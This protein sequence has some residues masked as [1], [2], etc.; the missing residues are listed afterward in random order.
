MKN[1]L[2]TAAISALMICSAQ[3]Q[4]SDNPYEGTY[5]GAMVGYNSYSLGDLTDV[6]GSVSEKVG[7]ATFGGLLGF[8]TELSPGILLG[9]EGFANS[10]QANKTYIVDDIPVELKANA[11]YGL[12]ATLGFNVDTA[13]LFIM[14]GYG[15]NGLAV[16]TPEIEDLTVSLTGK[17]FRGGVG[18]EFPISEN[19]G[20]RVQGDWH[21]FGDNISAL[22]G[23]VGVVFPF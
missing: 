22:G 2:C 5:F 10:N 13:L 8:R 12:N 20:M 3:A 11:S 1:Y 15:W 23:S 7:G 21:G 4:E 6:G 17:G 16:S 14:A 18:I 19:M 9:I